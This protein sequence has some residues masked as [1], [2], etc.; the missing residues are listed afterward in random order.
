MRRATLLPRA[1]SYIRVVQPI[2]SLSA[3]QHFPRRTSSHAETQQ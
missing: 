1:W 3:R 2:A